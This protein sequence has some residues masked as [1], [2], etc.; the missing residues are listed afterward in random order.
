MTI[1]DRYILLLAMWPPA[2]QDIGTNGGALLSQSKLPPS[3][4]IIGSRNRPQ[5]LLETVESVLRGDELPTELVIID[6]SDKP[7]PSLKDWKHSDSCEIR[8]LWRRSTGVCRARNE[9]IV[10]A[11]YDLVALTDDDLCATPTW[12]GSLIHSLVEAGPRSVVT[13]RVLPGAAE[14]PGGF[15]PALVTSQEY[16]VYEG[17]IGTDVLVTCHMAMHRS[18]FEEVGGFDDRLG[19]GTRFPAADDNDYGFRLL[20]RGYRIIYVPEAIIYHRAWRSQRE[21]LPMR[22]AYGRGTGGF[23]TKYLSL[24][25]PYMG[26]RMCRDIGLRLIRFPW[27]MLH[28]PDLALGDL[29]FACGIIWGAGEWL[30]TR[31]RKKLFH[32]AITQQ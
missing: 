1:V 18:T 6:Q 2:L 4:L 31:S 7:H 28:R 30:L 25:D 15:V 20:E 22:W 8:Y 16:K 9:G 17:R 11:R 21:Y 3:S 5:L 26:R 13:G 14:R 29:I 12:Y 10:A 27:R 23:Y 24:R 32:A 19:P